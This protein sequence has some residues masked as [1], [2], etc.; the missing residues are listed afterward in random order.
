MPEQSVEEYENTYLRHRYAAADGSVEG[1]FTMKRGHIPPPTIL[2]SRPL[3]GTIIMHWVIKNGSFNSTEVHKPSE[4][5][6][7]NDDSVDGNS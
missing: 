1:W 4:A 2:V 5:E 3:V 6:E 7:V